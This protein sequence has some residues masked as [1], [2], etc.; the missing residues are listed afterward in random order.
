[1]RF[2]SVE[3]IPYALPFKEPYVTARG[4]LR[5]REM[6]L[7][8]VRDEDGVVGLGEAVPLALRGGAS[9]GDVV[10]ELEGWGEH[11]EVQALSAPAR[12]AVET[13]LMDLRG[14]RIGTAAGEG[15]R[16]EAVECNATLVAGPPAEVA[17]EAEKWAR[18]GFT[19]FKLKLGAESAKTVDMRR[20]SQTRGSGDVEQVRAVREALGPGVRIRVDANEAWD[21]ETAKA[22]LAALEPFEVELAEQPVAGLEAMAELAANTSIPLAADESVA[23]LAEAE[24][25]VA[26]GACAYTG[27]KLSKVGGPEEA[28]A[29][30]DV[31]P[32]YVTSALDG[33]VGIAAAAQV[34]LSLAETGH[35][36]RLHL[37]HGLATQRL[38]ASTIASVE[39]EVRDGM[40]HLPPG[41]GL[42]V[43]IDED[44]LQAHRI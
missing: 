22:T 8:R 12:C 32:A 34:A 15:E 26:L 39:C 5:R 30:S 33:P 19:T 37:A 16:D 43:E 13:A 36:E 21:L 41:P 40:L 18:D 3:V 2:N 23:T 9:L 35:P 38:F 4:V 29:I 31:L 11:R 25:A 17:A 20:F 14:R 42:G 27:I 44:A 6:V 24:E 28:L 10:R 1:M 7:L